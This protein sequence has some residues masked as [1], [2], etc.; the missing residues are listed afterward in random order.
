[1]VSKWGKDTQLFH[2]SPLEKPQQGTQQNLFGFSIGKI[3]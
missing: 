1:M 3:A 2:A